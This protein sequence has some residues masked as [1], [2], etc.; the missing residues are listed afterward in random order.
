MSPGH[1]GRDGIVDIEIS[2]RAL[3]DRF[4]MEKQAMA[5]DEQV[6]RLNCEIPDSVNE[7]LNTIIPRGV[8]SDIIR[9][10]V[11]VFIKGAKEN[12]R[13][14]VMEVLDEKVKL[15]ATAPTDGT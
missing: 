13:G 14:F 1:V 10:L 8:K 11:K 12:G 3:H 2:Y 9:A 7:T 15:V 6:T 4:L 5:D